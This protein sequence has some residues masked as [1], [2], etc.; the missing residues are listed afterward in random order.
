M[1]NLILAS[2][3]EVKSGSQMWHVYRLSENTKSDEFF[4][5]QPIKA[6]RYAFL[7]RK[8]SGA[9]LPKAIYTKLM[10]DVSASKA[11]AEQ[12]A[13]Q[14]SAAPEAEQS[15][16]AKAFEQMKSKH[17]DAVLLFRMGDFYGSFAD[18]AKILSEVLGITLKRRNAKDITAQ[19]AAFPAYALDTY[20]PKLV[21]AGKHVAIC[22]A[23]HTESAQ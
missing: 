9:I 20:L 18:D 5:A 8:R 12:A 11:Q 4:F 14:E 1:A 21:R 16:L 10:A 6:L 13:P 2:K 17:P 7:L 15:A 23:P 22:D 3:R 19:Q